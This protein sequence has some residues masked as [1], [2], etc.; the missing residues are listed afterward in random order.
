V[1]V[2]ITRFLSEPTAFKGCGAAEIGAECPVGDG[3]TDVVAV[4][5]GEGCE[6]GGGEGGG[7]VGL[8]FLA[9]GFETAGF[10][11]TSRGLLVDWGLNDEMVGTW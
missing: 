8:P 2:Y 11:G 1:D 4:V 10:E 3:E 5:V 7:P 9:G 6:E